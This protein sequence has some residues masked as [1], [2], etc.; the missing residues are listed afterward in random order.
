MKNYNKI[1]IPTILAFITELV[2]FPS[3]KYPFEF[4][5]ISNI[6]KFFKIR[7]ASFTDLFFSGPRWISYW[8]N[9]ICYNISNFSPVIYRQLNILFHITSGILLF[10][11]IFKLLS[12]LNKNNFL[13]ENKLYISA[14][15]AALFLLHPVQSQTVS[16]II[17][18]QLEGLAALFSLIILNLF[19]LFTEINNQIKKYII[20]ITPPNFTTHHINNQF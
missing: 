5:D 17:Q 15:T 1:I 12:K 19:V 14:I 6:I 9:T 18:G 2:Y 3:L 4:D 13:N 8:I 10:Y 11:L 20:L 7:S 16:Y